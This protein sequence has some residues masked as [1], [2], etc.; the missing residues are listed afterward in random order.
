VSS[1]LVL[2]P[3]P[4]LEGVSDSVYVALTVMEPG[5]PSSRCWTSRANVA[6]DLPSVSTRVG[7]DQTLIA[8]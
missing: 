7:P 3:E 1:R 8:C 5:K 2:F 4:V 6:E